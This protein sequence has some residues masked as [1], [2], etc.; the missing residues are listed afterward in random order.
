MT[1]TLLKAKEPN[2]EILLFEDVI[3][4]ID[5][6]GELYLDKKLFKAIVD[7]D[8]PLIVSYIK[9]GANANFVDPD[10]GLTPL[11]YAICRGNE[12]MVE[13]LLENGAGV[14]IRDFTG[15]TPLH[16]SALKGTTKIVNLLLNHKADVNAVDEPDKLAPLH[17]SAYTG[18]P[19][20]TSNFLSIENIIVNPRDNNGITPLH[21]AAIR[22]KRDILEIL[23]D[24]MIK[25]GI[26][27]NQPD[28]FKTTAL[29]YAV[30]KG[31]Q[32]IVSYLLER[33]AE[34]E[35]KDLSGDTP[36]LLA[37]KRGR[38]ELVEI[39]LSNGADI[40]ATNSKGYTIFHIASEH[41]NKSLLKFL[42][43]I[44]NIEIESSGEL[45]P[46]HCAAIENKKES[47]KILLEEGAFIN[48]EDRAK[49]TPLHYAAIEGHNDLVKYFIQN[50]ADINTKDINGKTS[51]HYA[52]EKN[53][54]SLL[55]TLIEN[56]AIINPQVALEKSPLYYAI[57]SKNPDLVEVLINKGADINSNGDN[58]DEP[59]LFRA[60]KS[61]NKT[62]VSL[63]ID[64]NV[65]FIS[66]H[67]YSPL[68]LAIEKGCLDIAKFL[69]EKGMNINAKDNS[70]NTPLHIAAKNNDSSLI[71]LLLEKGADYNIP[72][73]NGDIPSA[74][75][76][77]NPNLEQDERNK[78]LFIT[79]NENNTKFLEAVTSRRYP[80]VENL[81]KRVNLRAKDEFGNTALHIAVA[82][83]DKSMIKLLIKN[84]ASINAKNMRGL[85]CLRSLLCLKSQYKH[86]NYK[87]IK[88]LFSRTKVENEN[89]GI[90]KYSMELLETLSS[91]ISDK[92]FLSNLIK[93]K[94]PQIKNTALILTLK[95][96]IDE[97]SKLN[98]INLLLSNGCD[99]S[100]CLDS[101]GDTALHIAVKNN[102]LNDNST[103]RK[104]VASIV[105]S[106]NI[107]LKKDKLS[108]SR[109]VNL[110]DK[111]GHTPLYYA[112][113]FQTTDEYID[114]ENSIDELSVGEILMSVGA[115]SLEP[116]TLNAAYG[117]SG[118]TQ[119]MI[120][121]GKGNF[122][123]VHE[124]IDKIE[125]YYPK[126][127][128]EN[129]V[130]TCARGI[131]G[132][133]Y[134]AVSY[135][136]GASRPI[137]CNCFSIR[138]ANSY[139][140]IVDLLERKGASGSVAPNEEISKLILKYSIKSIECILNLT[141]ESSLVGK[142]LYPGISL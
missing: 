59:T 124:I 27:L 69:I 35:S 5:K 58:F 44:M 91:N 77:Y 46:L 110:K 50:R 86:S 42:S 19:S 72:N 29:H 36:L 47:V 119:L 4:P 62:I 87:Q 140:N 17:I 131:N 78:Q 109:I 63:L 53:N 94:S 84:G 142:L 51:L 108:L 8:I 18:N 83:M 105:S 114:H 10:E 40:A 38:V 96:S 7:E 75:I 60:V 93:T 115:K 80:V 73:Q 3:S 30:L 132:N 123:L 67:G 90:N 66:Y 28:N 101:N 23:C 107:T 24:H 21:F 95:S 103:N 126:N 139:Q 31:N 65:L 120:A 70:G 76:P 11:L 9:S 48:S 16:Y 2:D 106:L 26:N 32:H 39:L 141:L 57:E 88:Q 56:G 85:S 41:E 52:A 128:V 111:K 49:R 15:R 118:V 127:E 20:A 82:S 122:A 71:E 136:L 133:L 34:T 54:K 25:R 100:N 104:I 116:Q 113:K 92:S 89:V 79:K 64:E 1:C 137:T 130:N 14:N 61:G 13:S 97:E 74:L 33:G 55:L 12:Q 121:C 6:G 45:K 129:I 112:N 102:A 99:A 98:I 117:K 68:H 135:A 22:G 43:K 37:G 81:I 134:T 125:E 138:R